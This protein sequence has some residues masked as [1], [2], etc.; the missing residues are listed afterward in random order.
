[1][2]GMRERFLR[3]YANVPDDIREDILAVVD[4]E[5]Y[6]WKTSY[7]AIKDNTYKGKKILKILEDMKIL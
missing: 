3:A 2:A 1:M 4:G 5:P 7:L 6:T